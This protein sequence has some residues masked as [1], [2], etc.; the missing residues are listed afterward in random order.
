MRF[1]GFLYMYKTAL[2]TIIKFYHKSG[3]IDLK[4]F[5]LSLINDYEI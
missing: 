3:S 2:S 1:I 4:H 5:F